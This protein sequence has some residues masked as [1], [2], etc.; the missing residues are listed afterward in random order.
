MKTKTLLV[1][2]TAC[3]ALTTTAV[4]ASAEIVFLTS[5]GV[6]SVK[7]HK[8]DGDSIVLT[9][10]S[11]GQVTCDKT[12]IE[13]IEA[14]EVPYPEP[15][16]AEAPAKAVGQFDPSILQSTPYGEIIASLSE[17]HGVDP[18]LVRALI[19]VESGY[20]PRARSAKGAMGLMQLMPSTA[21]EYKLRNPFDPKANIEAGIKHLKGLLDRW[22]GVDLALAAYNAGEA[23]VQKFNGIPPYRETRNYV[24][25][26][27]AIAGR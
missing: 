27:M 16:S 24:S 15:P 13:K 8:L 12:L 4:S 6:L 21:R 2:L 18:M 19:Q 22:K 11:G 5:G 10:R 7:N 23:A 3:L 9:L 25:R 14:D 26:I 20:K 17:A 1:G